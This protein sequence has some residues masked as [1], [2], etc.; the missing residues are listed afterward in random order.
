MIG[1]YD[2]GSVV[3]RPVFIGLALVTIAM[4]VLG[5]RNKNKLEYT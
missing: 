2:I 4:L 3:T 1:I 5:F